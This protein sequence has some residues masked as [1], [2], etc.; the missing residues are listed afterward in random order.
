MDIRKDRKQDGPDIT[1]PAIRDAASV[2]LF[3]DADSSPRVLIG[4]RGSTAVFMPNKF[5]FPGGAVGK[6]DRDVALATPLGSACIS[7]LA[8]SAPPEIV[9]LLAPCA[10]RELSEE[11]GLMLA[12][13]SEQRRLHEHP[14]WKAFFG[15][16]LVPSAKGLVYFY[17]ALTP[18]G[19]PRRFDTRFFLGVLGEVSL[20][21]DPDDFSGASDELGRLQWFPVSDAQELDL[22]YISRVVLNEAMLVLK[23]ERPPPS[24]PFHFFENGRK[25]IVRV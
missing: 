18:P 10:V 21:G 3:R 8:R 1:D 19:L 2:L 11:T 20:A 22:P 14:S 23:N 13:K 5:V 12:E 7:R 4:Q 16:N 15:S 25:R 9:S 6:E 24:V 17:R